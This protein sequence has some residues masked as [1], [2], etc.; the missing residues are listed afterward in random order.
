MTDVLKPRPL[1]VI[2]NIYTGP[3]D[4]VDPADVDLPRSPADEQTYALSNELSDES[5]I[6]TLPYPGLESGLQSDSIVFESSLSNDA[7]VQ[8]ESC[9]VESENPPLLLR[10]MGDPQSRMVRPA[11]QFR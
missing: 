8:R 10:D 5:S 4:Y 7:V 3:N 2:P 9:G 6:H 1:P 11:I